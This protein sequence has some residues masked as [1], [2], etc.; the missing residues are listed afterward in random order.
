MN[1]NQELLSDEKEKR[2]YGTFKRLSMVSLF[3]YICSLFVLSYSENLNIIPR[4]LFA[5][6]LVLSG[7]KCLVAKKLFKW[8]YTIFALIFMVVYNWISSFWVVCGTGVSTYMTTIPQLFLLYLVVR[9]NIE[10][11]KDLRLMFDAVVVGTMIMCFYCL[12]Y[13]GPANILSVFFNNSRIGTEVNQANG[14]GTY[15]AIAGIFMIYYIAWEKK[16]WYIPFLIVD[17]VIMLASASR[18][19]TLLLIVAVVV[20]LI[21]RKEK[22]RFKRAIIAV[23]L[24]IG[25]VYLLQYLAQINGF[26]YRMAQ[27]LEIFGG[28]TDD[29][30]D[31]SILTRMSFYELAF[32]L[33][34]RKPILGHGPVQFEYY[35]WLYNG[36]RRAPHSTYLQVLVGYGLLGFGAFY[37]MYVFFF[38][39]L[40]AFLKQNKKYSVLILALLIIHL[41]NDTGINY[42]ATK[43]LYL[44]LAI[45]ACYLNM[46]VEKIPEE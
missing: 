5:I 24:V 40:K 31:G 43:F 37:G 34:L 12:L 17:L 7:L 27:T 11:L 22:G 26:F 45:F 6:L 32:K 3:A 20:M 18:R 16:K 44:F 21:M 13:Y 4:G 15:C 23:V 35:N 8:D 41:V 33:F 2:K 14:M 28:R 1:G 36:F 39:K 19:S 42:F 10:D 46:D 30:T 25:I 29:L 9:I 38:A